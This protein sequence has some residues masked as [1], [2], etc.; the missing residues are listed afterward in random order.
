MSLT[1]FTSLI[2]MIFGMV[3]FMLT[4]LEGELKKSIKKILLAVLGG[5]IVLILILGAGLQYVPKVKTAVQN[6]SDDYN[7]DTEKDLLTYTDDSGK[8]NKIVISKI[9]NDAENGIYI[10]NHR[11]KFLF[12]YDDINVLHISKD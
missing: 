4:P 5:I 2:I 7:Y 1:R 10:E 8:Q 6:I 12:I 3:M 9:V 11:K